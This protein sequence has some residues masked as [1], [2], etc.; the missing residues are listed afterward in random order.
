MSR[1]AEHGWAGWIAR[2]E[3]A[4]ASERGPSILE[5]IADRVADH[6]FL[7]R[8]DSVLD[9]GAG[10]GLLTFKAAR[11]VGRGG[12]V[13]A[14]DADEECLQ[15]L[16]VR[17]EAMGLENVSVHHGRMES[18]PLEAGS[19]DAVICRSALSYS[20]DLHA[21]ISEINRVLA[22]GGRFSLFEPLP[23][24][25]TW[26]FATDLDA[27]RFMSMEHAL[28]EARGNSS[29]TRNVIRNML[30]SEFARVESLTVHYALSFAG[31]DEE[32]L[33]EEYLYDLPGELGAFYVLKNVMK[34]EEIIES[35]RWFARAASAGL[36]RGTLPCLFAWGGR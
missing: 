7:H 1:G 20:A 34:A 11:Q 31:R 36:V 30:E 27:G 25:T 4:A 15:T 8:G 21:A 33:A 29:L 2:V 23:G 24:E 5:G 22:P 14:L 32:E 16:R 6:A 13:V 19:F 12:V 26:S 17:G 9:L 18:L 35:A 10:T 28:R 3:R